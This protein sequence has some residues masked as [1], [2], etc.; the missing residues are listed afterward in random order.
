MA[1]GAPAFSE[2]YHCCT[3]PSGH[4][5]QARMRFMLNTALNVAGA[6]AA[7]H[8]MEQATTL[9][10]GDNV[11]LIVARDYAGGDSPCGLSHAAGIGRHFSR[12]ILCR[13]RE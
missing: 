2:V 1:Q 12:S 13:D 6:Q 11:T 9:L 7:G 4:T 8:K 5:V 10:V 3:Q